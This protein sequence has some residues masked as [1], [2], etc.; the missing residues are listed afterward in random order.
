MQGGIILEK[1]KERIQ[2][3]KKKRPGYG[4]ML[5]FYQKV[6]EAQQS[7][8]VSLKIK[9]VKLKKEWKELLAKEGFSLIQKE[10]FPLNIEASIKLF[11]TLLQ[12]GKDAN[13]HM[14]E[15]VRKI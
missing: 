13:P 10:D 4:E 9:P 8:K 7:T 2:Q 6:K 11:G 12:I 14:T 3:I 15:K 1:L 5:D